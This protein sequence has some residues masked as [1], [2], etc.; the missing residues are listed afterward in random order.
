M[1]RDAAF[2]SVTSQQLKNGSRDRVL[3]SVAAGPFFTANV[4]VSIRSKKVGSPH[5]GPLSA[6]FSV[7]QGQI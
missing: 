1:G 4:F 2:F 6:S 3:K 5:P 7:S